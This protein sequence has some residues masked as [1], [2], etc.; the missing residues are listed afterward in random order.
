MGS[1]YEPTFIHELVHAIDHILPNYEYE[2]CYNEL[3]AELST[4]ILCKAYNIPIDIPYSLYYLNMYPNSEVNIHKIINR[5]ALIY[6]TIKKCI[7]NIKSKNN[8][9]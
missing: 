5:V 6:E 2:L 8:G 3:I 7:K 9:T 4:I 1:D